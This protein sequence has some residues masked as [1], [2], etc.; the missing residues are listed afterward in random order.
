[1]SFT[2]LNK[3]TNFL[4]KR[5][6]EIKS[7]HSAHLLMTPKVNGENYRKFEPGPDAS[8]SAVLLLLTGKDNK[9]KILLTLRAKTLANH[10]GQISFPGGKIEEKETVIDAALRETEEETGIKPDFIKII[11][12]L[13]PLFVA[14]SN[15]IIHPVVGQIDF[16]EINLKINN[17]EVEEVFFVDINDLYDDKKKIIEKWDLNGRKVDVPFW[18]IHKSIPLWGATAMI[19]SEFLVIS[20]PYFDED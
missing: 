16:N 12:E 2:N 5:L 10:S 4:L 11:G 19:L 3:Y 6:K 17:D 20:K 1:M 7:G 18:K 13:S 8:K 15:S 14:P 9:I